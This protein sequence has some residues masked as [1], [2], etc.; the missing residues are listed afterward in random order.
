MIPE[1]KTSVSRGAPSANL[2]LERW[3]R[4]GKTIKVLR[5][6]KTL[7]QAKLAALAQDSNGG[8]MVFTKGYLS[9]IE[10]GV[11]N[12]GSEVIDSILATLEVSDDV[13]SEKHEADI[14]R[15]PVRF[16]TRETLATFIAKDKLSAED[17]SA[18]RTMVDEVGGP[19]G[20]DEWRQ[21]YP[22]LTAYAKAKKAKATRRKI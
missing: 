18:L 1:A 14:E 22:R 9:R 3:E 15:D 13:L 17:A 8:K 6:A 20:V 19:V 5:E 4:R 12:V 16:M 7:T 2:R 11:R 10:K 21:L